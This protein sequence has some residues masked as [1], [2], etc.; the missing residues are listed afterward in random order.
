MNANIVRG[1]VAVG[2]L[3]VSGAASAAISTTEALA[4]ITDAQTA[5][6]AVIAGMTTFAIAVW[7]VK[8]LL[9]MFGSTR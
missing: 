6:L 9:R 1:L 4:G 8:K 7:G 2:V 5:V 3:A